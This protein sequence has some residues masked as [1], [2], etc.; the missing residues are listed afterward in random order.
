VVG[1]SFLMSAAAIGLLLVQAG[2]GGIQSM[3][4]SDVE[5]MIAVTLFA[6]GFPVVGWVVVRRRPRNP[7]AWTYLAIGF[8]DSLDLFATAYTASSF[9]AGAAQPPFAAEVSWLSIWAWAPAFTLFSTLAILLFPTGRLPSRRWWPVV[10]LTAVAA[11]M[12]LVPVA[13]ASWP[14]RG[15]ILEQAQIGDMAPPPG[16]ALAIAF[17]IQGVGQLVLLAAMLGSIG[18]LASRFRGATGVERQQLKWFVFAALVDVVII[19]VWTLDVLGLW[20]GIATALIVGFSLP[21]AIGVAI[22]RHRLYDIDLIIRRT[23][24]YGVL[25]AALAAVYTILVIAAETLLSGLVRT[26]SPLAVALS[27]LAVA[28][29]FGPLRHRI[30]VVV[31]RRFYRSRYDAARSL[32]ALGRGLREQVDLPGITDDMTRVVDRAVRPSSLGIWLRL[33]TGDR[34][35]PGSVATQ[36]AAVATPIPPD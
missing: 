19:A 23:L 34:P 36:R 35:P 18:G 31:D 32:E 21:V 10:V 2:P 3:Q 24:V 14:Y 30:Q 11:V 26:G 22:G 5:T 27:T 16:T 33:G 6:V 7:L 15:P 29:L 13:V 25:S 28:T 8:W 1:A 9:L 12:L 20:L 4:V 17:D